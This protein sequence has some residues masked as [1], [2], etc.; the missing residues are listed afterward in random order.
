MQSL[1]DCVSYCYIK[2]TSF[3][4]LN[5]GVQADEAK[6][7]LRCVHVSKKRTATHKRHARNGWVSIRNS[8]SV[9]GILSTADQVHG[10]VASMY[11]ICS[12]YTRRT[13]TI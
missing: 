7:E 4:E 6:P 1:R 8:T 2:L 3:L 10:A 13:A 12:Q 5:G 11:L 9:L